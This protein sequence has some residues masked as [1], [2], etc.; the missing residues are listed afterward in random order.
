MRRLA[1][2]TILST[3]FYLSQYGQIEAHHYFAN[4]HEEQMVLR[5]KIVDVFIENPHGILTV[6]A[7]GHEWDVYLGSVRH[8]NRVGLSEDLFRRGDP[9]VIYG[10][11]SVNPDDFELMSI[12]IIYRGKTYEIFQDIGDR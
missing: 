1:A 7:G 2:A 8:S 3:F 9:I 11:P 10:H 6:K 4:F 5:G 12:R